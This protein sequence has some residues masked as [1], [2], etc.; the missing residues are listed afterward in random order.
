MGRRCAIVVSVLVSLAA[1]VGATGC[2]CCKPVGSRSVQQGADLPA[3]VWVRVRDPLDAEVPWKAPGSFNI[4][5]MPMYSFWVGDASIAAGVGECVVVPCL[6][7]CSVGSPAP[8]W[9]RGRRYVATT[10]VVEQGGDKWVRFDMEPGGVDARALNERWG[11][12]FG[13]KR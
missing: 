4:G 12:G 2:C 3:S 10:V 5:R 8:S 7:E 1:I 6:D 9:D 13:G 11:G